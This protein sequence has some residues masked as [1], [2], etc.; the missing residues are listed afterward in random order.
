MPDLIKR[1]LPGLI[2]TVVL[3]PASYA[4]SLLWPQLADDWRKA[5]AAA[6]VVGVLLLWYMPLTQKVIGQLDS[7]TKKLATRTRV[8]FA[9]LKARNE[10]FQAWRR[11][12]LE[13]CRDELAT[14]RDRLETKRKRTDQATQALVTLSQGILALFDEI[15]QKPDDLELNGAIGV[16][17][18]AERYASAALHHHVSKVIFYDPAYPGSWMEGENAEKTRDYFTERWFKE[19]NA[20]QLHDWMS[21]AIQNKVAHRSL[22]VFAQDIVPE[23]VAEVPN[24]TCLIRKYLQAGG[25]IVWRGDIPFW[26]QGKAGEVKEK[27]HKAGPKD[28]LGITYHNHLIRSQYAN[29][30]HM[31]DS[32][33][34]TEVTSS[35]KEI[36]V[37]YSGKCTRPVEC[38]EVDSI[39]VL[40]PQDNFTVVDISSRRGKGDFALCWKKRFNDRYPYGGFMQYTLGRF[41]WSDDTTRAFFAFAVSGWPLL[42]ER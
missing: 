13:R 23:T 1:L 37:D 8:T 6:V 15:I 16:S 18:Q 11:G 26:Y 10:S 40:V 19:K 42:F 7:I 39:Y 34:P 28:V 5:I 20:Q 31:W 33:L 35:G 27:W 9:S 22:V 2:I 36:G 30:G 21:Q 3:A 41:S 29:D 25:R 12:D 24:E 32:D 14:A 4:V 17:K 38:Q